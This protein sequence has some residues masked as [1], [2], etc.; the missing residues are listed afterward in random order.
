VFPAVGTGEWWLLRIPMLAATAAVLSL[1]VLT[2]RG[3]ERPQRWETPGVSARRSH[4][5]LGTVV[6]GVLVLIGI[7]GL[8]VA[9]FAG[10]LSLRTAELVVVPMASLPSVL[11]VVLGYWLTLRWASPVSRHLPERT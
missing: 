2:F 6:G 11:L 8:S 9:G 4:R 1:L 5:D 10:V 3:F 7:L